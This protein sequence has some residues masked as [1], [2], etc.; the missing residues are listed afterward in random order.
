MAVQ[1]VVY[2]MCTV[3]SLRYREKIARHSINNL[4]SHWCLIDDD[5]DRH[6]L[7]TSATCSTVMSPWQ[8]CYCRTSHNQ[9]RRLLPI[10]ST[11]VLVT[12]ANPRATI[13]I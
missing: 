6:P 1:L 11:E 3:N 9:P 4:S 12:H 2:A 10:A 13:V 8:H 7:T 5:D